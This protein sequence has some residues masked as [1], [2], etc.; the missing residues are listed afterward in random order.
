MCDIKDFNGTLL[1][2]YHAITIIINAYDIR[3]IKI[4]NNKC[5]CSTPFYNEPSYYDLFSHLHY[6]RIYNIK[7]FLE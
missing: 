5:Q 1:I 4:N 6:T 7:T 2:W 3:K